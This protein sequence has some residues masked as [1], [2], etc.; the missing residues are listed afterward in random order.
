MT[1]AECLDLLT[2]LKNVRQSE[3]VGDQMLEEECDR[4][5]KLVADCLAEP[6][7]VCRWTRDE[8]EDTSWLTQCGERFVSFDGAEP[9]VNSYHF[10]P[11]C[12]ASI[13]VAPASKAQL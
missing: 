4:L 3:Y 12:G 13:Q 5:I 2:F 11:K 1:N 6:P 8:F 10:C 7:Q 9:A